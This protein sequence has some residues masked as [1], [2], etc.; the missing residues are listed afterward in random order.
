ML[1]LVDIKPTEAQRVVV[2]CALYRDGRRQRDIA[3]E[4][5]GAVLGCEDGIIWLGL[6]EPDE[7]LLRILQVQLG[8][9]ELMIEDAN[10]AHQRAKLDVY[11]NCLFIV[12]RTA[13]SQ[14]REIQYGETHLIIGKGS[15]CRSDTAPRPPMPK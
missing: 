11:D 5:M 4:E 6:H 8:L 7:A 15:S 12:L 1:D 14:G 2:A 9:H 10:Q 3:V 13:Q